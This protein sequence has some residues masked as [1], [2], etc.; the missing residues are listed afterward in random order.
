MIK[1]TDS[2]WLHGLTSVDLGEEKPGDA[3]KGLRQ[4][5]GV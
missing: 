2:R 5:L 4:R 1:S 3:F